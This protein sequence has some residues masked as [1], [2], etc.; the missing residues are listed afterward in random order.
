V[1]LTVYNW[2]RPRDVSHYER[3]E[4]YHETFYQQ[5]EALSVTPFAK[6]ALDRGLTGVLVSYL[7]LADE[8][9]NENDD[10]DRILDY[11]SQVELAKDIISERAQQ[12]TSSPTVYETIQQMLQQRIDDWRSKVRNATAMIGY[13]GRRDDRTLPLLH[14][15]AEEDW[16]KFT[17][18]NSLRE[19][20]PGVRLIHSDY[21]MDRESTVSKIEKETSRDE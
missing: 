2:A 6:R 21:G 4:H 19:V 16:T 5:V 12:I 20:E 8:M 18:L 15:P 11:E 3:F 14:K 17:C 7:R 10:A 13:Q 1:V 9:L